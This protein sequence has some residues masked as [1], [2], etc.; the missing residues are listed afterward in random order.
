MHDEWQKVV[1]DYPGHEDPAWLKRMRTVANR[2]LDQM[3]L[4]LGDMYNHAGQ[5]G[6]VDVALSELTSLDPDDMFE[7]PRWHPL[8]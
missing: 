7:L 1:S 2:E 4:K 5:L 6:A 8:Q 3:G